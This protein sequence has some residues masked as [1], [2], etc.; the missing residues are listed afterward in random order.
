DGY[1]RQAPRRSP[2]PGNPSLLA[3]RLVRDGLLTPFQAGQ[4]LRGR[5]RGFYLGKY[6]VLEPIA[7]GGMGRVLLG[8]HRLMQRLVA[9][10]LLPPPQHGDRGAILRLQREGRAMAALDH[11]N[12]VRAYDLDQADRFHFLVLEFI[13]GVNLQSLVLRHGPLSVERS[14]DTIRQ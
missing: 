8:T 13:D 12:I 6:K 4:L 10:Q 3:Q 2:E 14:L 7:T 1:L 9:V 11:P 5:W